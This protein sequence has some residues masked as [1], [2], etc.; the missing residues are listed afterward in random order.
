MWEPQHYSTLHLG[1]T[2]RRLT[3][4]ET[5]VCC[6]IP[7]KQGKTVVGEPSFKTLEGR[8]IMLYAFIKR[9]IVNYVLLNRMKYIKNAAPEQEYNSFNTHEVIL[10]GRVHDR[11]GLK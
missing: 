7:R 5:I 2:E 6:N 9:S 3:C 11:N 10:P 4:L 1:K 8:V